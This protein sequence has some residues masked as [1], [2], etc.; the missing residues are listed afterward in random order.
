MGLANAS[1]ISVI[2]FAGTTLGPENGPSVLPERRVG[3]EGSTKVKTSPECLWLN[4]EFH[5]VSVE[6]LAKL[7]AERNEFE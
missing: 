3:S 6:P 4:S 7:Q 5:N 1:E 2:G